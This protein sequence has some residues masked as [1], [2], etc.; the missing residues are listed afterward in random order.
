MVG[1]NTEVTEFRQTIASQS[2]QRVV[3]QWALTRIACNPLV[4][5][6]DGWR[7]SDIAFWRLTE[8]GR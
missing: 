7:S 1:I 8:Q 4:S 3:K 5:K 2:C 6:W